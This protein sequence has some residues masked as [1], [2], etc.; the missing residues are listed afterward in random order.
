MSL[1]MIE[2]Y[3][4]LK[5]RLIFW[6]SLVFLMAFIF[7]G[8]WI[9]V[10]LDKSLHQELD[11]TLSKEANEIAEKIKF[12]EGKITFVDLTEL[13]EP[14]HLYLNEAS[15]FLRVFDENLNLIIAS[16][17][18]EKSG[19]IIPKPDRGKLSGANEVEI[20]GKRL[21]IFYLPIYSDGKF[22]G[23]IEASK[24]EGTVQVAMG[25]LRG[26]LFLALLL[27][28][29]LV[30]Y[31][32]NI[33]ISKLINPLEQ[34]IDKA[35]KISA[36][37]LSERIEIKQKNPPIEIV[38]LVLTL[39]KLLDGLEKSFKQISQFTSNVAHELLTPLTVI[40]DEIEIT[41]MK[42]RRS[43]EYIQTLN[44]IQRQTDR[45][46][47]IIKS[48]LYLAKADAGIVKANFEKT[49]IS[50]LLSELV[51]TFN[52]KAR[53]KNI[54]IKLT[55]DG[56]IVV[57]TDDKIL[58]EALKN[59]IDNAIEYT[60]YGGKVEIKCEKQNKQV[61]I[62]ISDTGIGIDAD[63]LPYIFDRFFRGKSAFEINPS[64]TG[65]GLAL[66]KAMIEILS[67]KIEVSSK[68]GKGTEFIVYIPE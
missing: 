62:S 46:I 55:C 38:K 61:K 40:K 17:N 43:S 34:V 20:N 23:L 37:N 2:K 36:E 5:F 59:I 15:V 45:S 68:P 18:L 50:E 3:K 16:H 4:T 6:Y 7:G 25:F 9:Y 52:L 13:N 64:G 1:K 65:L 29:T 35:D 33:L 54:T 21:R 14:E 31:G 22:G 49:D 44:L 48:M 26:S 67:G 63:E 10:Y 60:G 41:L 53:Q 32:G 30:V 12:V 24:F 39:N 47:A 8:M 11:L 51:L 42:R 27:A 56:E 58:F 57:N 66:T 28:F 19:M